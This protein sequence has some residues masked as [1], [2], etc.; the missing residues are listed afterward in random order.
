MVNTY[1]NNLTIF[2]ESLIELE[3]KLYH[4]GLEKIEEE[5]I[6]QLEEWQKNQ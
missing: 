6:R 3:E 1:D 5:V 2:E 4:A